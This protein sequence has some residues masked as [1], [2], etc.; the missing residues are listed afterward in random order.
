MSR[1]LEEMA[2]TLGNWL[3]AR[4]PGAN[5]IM[6]PPPTRPGA[7]GSSDTLLVDP[8]IREG[9]SERR[10]RWV[11]RIEPSDNRVYL[12]QSVERQFRV[13]QALGALG[14]VP[15]PHV[16]WLEPD[17]AVLGAPFFLME[18][19][20]G[21]I[22]HDL[23]H[24]QGILADA[25]PATRGALWLEAVRSMAAIHATPVEPFAFLARPERGATGLVQEV[26]L[27]D[28]YARWSG[29]PIQPVQ[30]R[31]RGWL[32]GHMPKTQ[33][34]GL[35]W[36]DARPGNLVFRDGRCAAVLD[37]E[38]VSL[39]GAE[40]DLGWWM[41]FDW[42][43]SDGMG[44]PRL[45]GIGDGRALISAWEG[46]SGRKARDMEWHEVFATWRFSLI[47]DRARLL[48]RQRGQADPV[49]A[50]VPSPHARRLEMLV[51]G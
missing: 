10:E 12:D 51:G 27:W 28:E 17:P 14:T 18:R 30:N 22:P 1:N 5:S 37:W 24:S 34:D 11:L 3:H 50:G 45:E 38:T 47:S 33:P 32:E 8:V 46:F 43:V 19:V 6:V 20:E 44:I 39:M 21:A 49:P 40:S 25:Q 29:A 9:G 4:L 31:A 7:G 26:A 41:F 42:M 48:M 35:A 2:G 16:L 36:G 15:V 23:Y 13:M